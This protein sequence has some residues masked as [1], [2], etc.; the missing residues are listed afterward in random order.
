MDTSSWT[1]L[2]IAAFP[3]LA[4]EGFE[5]VGEPTTQYNCIAYAAGYASDWWWPDG[6]NYWPPWATPTE[7]TES[8]IEVFDGLGYEQCDD[9][10][11]ETG[12]QKV[13]LYEEE[14]EMKHAAVQMSD[15]AWRSKMGQGPLIEHRSPESLSGGI[16]GDAT[17]YMRRA[18]N[19]NL[20]QGT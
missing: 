8:L 20:A 3:R 15:G 11:A 1:Q 12:Y 9:S 18:V 19:E 10:H 13:A 17:V 2:L 5:I 4:S 14:G 7:R 6:I 16:Y